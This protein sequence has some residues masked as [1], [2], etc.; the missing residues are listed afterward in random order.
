LQANRLNFLIKPV[1]VVAAAFLVGF[2]TYAI[3]SAA[4]ARSPTPATFPKV[5][6]A[7]RLSSGRRAPS[8]VLRELGG[9][10]GITFQDRSPTPVIVNFFASWCQDCVAELDA[11]GKISN[12]SSG[13]RFIGVDSLDSDPGLAMRLLDR[14]HITYAI[15][16]DPSG[17]IS[18]RYL[19]NGLPVTFF[20]SK[21]GV[22]EGE[23]FGTATSHELAQWVHR[24]GGSVR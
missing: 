1:T 21:T 2:L 7:S 11:F 24:L 3:F 19:I 9:E 17:A 13:V 5:P 12:E 6:P 14:A 22:I 16:V 18:N 10:R 20:V 15:G 8:F 4:T 23:I